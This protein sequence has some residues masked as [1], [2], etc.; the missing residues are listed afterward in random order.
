MLKPFGLCGDPK[1]NYTS[2]ERPT[3]TAPNDVA[4]QYPCLLRRIGKVLTP[5]ATLAR[6]T[7]RICHLSPPA[8]S[9]HLAARA[10]IQNGQNKHPPL[11]TSHS[12]THLLIC[13]QTLSRISIQFATPHRPPCTYNCPPTSGTTPSDSSQPHPPQPCD[14]YIENTQLGDAYD[15]TP[16]SSLRSQNTTR[17]HEAQALC[18]HPIYR[19]STQ[20]HLYKRTKNTAKPYPAPAMQPNRWT[21]IP[22]YRV[23][24]R[25]AG[26][27]INIRFTR[28]R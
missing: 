27:I 25:T 3:H 11:P 8:L 26:C 23:I 14:T 21:R 7:Y 2:T 5:P 18:T 24:G 19:L 15:S 10:S 22:P 20:Q 16:L 1:H 28:M 13:A 17:S 9:L 6:T 4:G 12:P